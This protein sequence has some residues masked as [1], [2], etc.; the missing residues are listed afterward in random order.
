[1][2]EL[3][4]RDFR[5]LFSQR[6]APC[7]RCWRVIHYDA[8]ALQSDAFAHGH[9]EPVSVTAHLAHEPSNFRSSCSRCNRYRG[10]GPRSR[11]RRRI[12]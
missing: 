8:P 9:A 7:W 12:R 1:M 2:T 4:V 6:H 10:N 11:P 5:V 3:S